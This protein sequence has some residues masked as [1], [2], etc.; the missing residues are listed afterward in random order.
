MK[1]A[2]VAKA[3]DDLRAE[4]DL[5]RLKGGVRGKYHRRAAAGIDVVVDGLDVSGRTTEAALGSPQTK[6]KAITPKG[7]KIRHPGRPRAFG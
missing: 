5:S 7:G 2:S 4:Y 3:S 6:K 1:K